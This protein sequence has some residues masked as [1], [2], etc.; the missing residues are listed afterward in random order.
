MAD[1]FTWDASRSLQWVRETRWGGGAT[2]DDAIEAVADEEV[3]G[4]FLEENDANAPEIWTELGF[5]EAQAEVLA[6]DVAWMVS[7]G[8]GTRPSHGDAGPSAAPAAAQPAAEDQS[9][10][11]AVWGQLQGQG[12]DPSLMLRD[13]SVLEQV[14]QQFG[15]DPATLQATLQ[16]E[17][18]AMVGQQAA[19]PEPALEEPEAQSDPATSF[20]PMFVTEPEQAEEMTKKPQPEP[21]PEPEPE[22]EREPEPGH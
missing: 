22:R 3:D 19:T 1:F 13:P 10:V 15:A 4:A 21:E 17:L 11:G 6:N 20:T 18:Q 12:I 9:P 2:P 5:T 16:Q 14:A 8:A 7:G